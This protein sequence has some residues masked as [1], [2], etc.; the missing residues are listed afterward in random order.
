[1]QWLVKGL[2]L[3]YMETKIREVIANYFATQPV[4]KVWVFGSFSRGEERTDSDID[5]LVALDKDQHIGL[6]FFGMR[7]ELSELLGREVDLATESSL[8]PFAKESVERDK[9][10]IYERKD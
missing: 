8:L 7:N 1:L 5:I 2:S 6:K 3:R 4:I 9:R 10:L